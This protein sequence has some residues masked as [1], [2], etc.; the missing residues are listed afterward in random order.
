MIAKFDLR[1]K[2]KFIFIRR[3]FWRSSDLTA[4]SKETENMNISV[5]T[6]QDEMRSHFDLM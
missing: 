6:Q 4:V 2:D 1:K 5:L 3:R